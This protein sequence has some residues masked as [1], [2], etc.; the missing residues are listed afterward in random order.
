MH[1]ASEWKNRVDHAGLIGIFEL[2]M[3]SSSLMAS[4]RIA[5]RLAP[6]SFGFGFFQCFQRGFDT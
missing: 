2:R 5:G 3:D 6:Q 4:K 1:G